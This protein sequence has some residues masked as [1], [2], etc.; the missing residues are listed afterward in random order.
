MAASRSRAAGGGWRGPSWATIGYVCSSMT[1]WADSND[2]EL[3]L[4][5]RNRWIVSAHADTGICSVSMTRSNLPSTGERARSE[6]A[7]PGGRSPR[8]RSRSLST[9]GL[10]FSSTDHQRTPESA[11]LQSSS[12]RLCTKRSSTRRSLPSRASA[13]T[14]RCQPRVI[15]RMASES[16]LNPPSGRVLSL[17][18]AQNRSTPANNQ[19]PNRV[20]WRRRATAVFPTLDGPS[21]RTTRPD[22]STRL[23][24]RA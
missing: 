10:A 21:K 17:S 14:A 16:V 8:P 7:S 3:P 4:S 9:S 1:G 13:A 20:A 6:A 22:M 5:D 23:L 12:H 2:D 11:S 19:I 18:I 24:V 15:R